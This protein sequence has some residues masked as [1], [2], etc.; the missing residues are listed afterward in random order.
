MRFR[1]IAAEIV[2]QP[3]ICAPLLTAHDFCGPGNQ[4][5]IAAL[6]RIVTATRMTFRTNAVDL[7]FFL[8]A[9]LDGPRSMTIN[10]TQAYGR[11]TSFYK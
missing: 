1:F 4:A 5:T 2:N 8:E 7:F 10:F 3:S 11:G 6:P 9:Q